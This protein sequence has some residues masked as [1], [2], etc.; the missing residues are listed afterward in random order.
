MLLGRPAVGVDDQVALGV[1]DALKCG[2]CLDVD[3]AA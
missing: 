1:I 3:E 2:A